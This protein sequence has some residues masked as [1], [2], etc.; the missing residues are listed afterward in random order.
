MKRAEYVAVVTRAY[1]QVL[2]ALKEE[3]DFKPE[4]DLK[5]RLLRIFNRNF[6]SGYFINGNTEFLST[7]RPNNRGVYV[8]RVVDQNREMLTRI[9]LSNTVNLG[10]GLVVWVGQGQ[11]PASI[12]KEM[13]IEGKNVSEAQSGQ[14]IDIQLEGRV[15]TNDRVFKTHDEKLLSEARESILTDDGFKIPLEAEIYLTSGKPMQL[16]LADHRGTR[17]EVQT[18]TLAQPAD[19]HPLNQEILQAKIGR[20]GNTPFELRNLKVH[21]DQD[22]LVPFSDINDTRRR[23]IDL[24]MQKILQE[25]QPISIDTHN[26]WI[27]KDRYLNQKPLS[28]QIHKTLLSIAVS[29]MEQVEMSLQNGTDSVYLGMEG[30]GTHHHLKKSQ[31]RDLSELNKGK[32]DRIIP[33]LPRIRKPGDSFLYREIASESFSTLMIASWADLEWGINR[34]LNILADYSLNVFNRY[35][36]RYLYDQGVSRVCLSPELNFSQLQTFGDC[37]KVELLVHGELIIMQSQF[38]M[39]GDVLGEDKKKCMAPCVG[40]SYYIKDSK[41]YEFPVETDSDCRF[42]IFN[43]RTLCM[44][45]DLPRILALKPSSIRIE[46]RRFSDL[47]LCHTV[48]IYREAINEV[49]NGSKPDL[50]AYQQELNAINNSSFTKGHYY[51]GVL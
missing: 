44:L 26:Y 50:R 47:Q 41:G 13:K 25:K 23:A 45:E 8:G 42:Y 3:P 40:K 2:D 33:I 4:P 48:K 32:T 11:A 10:D 34:G 15:Y 30:L 51:R 19:Q 38:C 27:E 5:E 49:L 9:K 36:L 22:L 18:K 28:E 17:V 16:V 39:L 29:N 43:S 31:L 6:S 20:L 7:R 35:T 1:R 21:S 24:L 37:D 12:V 46:A 14:I